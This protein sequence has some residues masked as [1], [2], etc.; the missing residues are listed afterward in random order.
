MTLTDV[1]A[2]LLPAV[3]RLLERTREQLEQRGIDTTGMVQ[4][5]ILKRA[6]EERLNIASEKRSRLRTQ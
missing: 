5:Q 2:H 4:H 6:K 1:P 3:D